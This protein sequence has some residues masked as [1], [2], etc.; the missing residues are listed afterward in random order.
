MNV[1][2]LND[3]PAIATAVIDTDYASAAAS[4]CMKASQFDIVNG[5]IVSVHK[6]HV[7]SS[8]RAAEYGALRVEDGPTPR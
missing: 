2:M 7:R 6:D 4:R 8:G 1:K 5:Q 3:I